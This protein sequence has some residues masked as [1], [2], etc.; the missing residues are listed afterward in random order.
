MSSEQCDL[1]NN[2]IDLLMYSLT[3][4][5]NYFCLLSPKPSHYIIGGMEALYVR[6]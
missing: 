1:D 6:P 5:E 4:R 2:N 3:L